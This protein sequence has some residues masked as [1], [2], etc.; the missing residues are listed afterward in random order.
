M[1]VLTFFR[2]HYWWHQCCFFYQQLN[3]D[4]NIAFGKVEQKYDSLNFTDQYQ[5]DSRE[6]QVAESYYYFSKLEPKQTNKKNLYVMFTY[7]WSQQ[8]INNIWMTNSGFVLVKYLFPRKMSH[9]FQ[10]V[11]QICIIVVKLFVAQ[12]KT[13][14]KD[15]IKRH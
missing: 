15:T 5:T 14:N 2:Q 4:Q 12:N 8:D 6:H 7:I 3:C 9:I 13:P 1:P 10:S 11:K